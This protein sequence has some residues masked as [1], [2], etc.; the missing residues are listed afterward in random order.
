MRHDCTAINANHDGLPLPVHGDKVPY[1][2]Q[3]QEDMKGLLQDLTALHDKQST[4]IL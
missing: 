4:F 1:I 3:D 2:S